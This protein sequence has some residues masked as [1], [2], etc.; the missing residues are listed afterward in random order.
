METILRIF[1]I[2][3]V[4]N[5]IL[6]V[7]GMLVIFRVAA[8]VAVPGVDATALSSIF[9]G[10]QLFGLL[11]IFSGGTLESFSVVAMGVAPYI[12]SSIIFQLLG[13]IVPQIEE[14]QKEEQGKQK[15]TQW[16]RLATVPLGLI[17][18]YG[19]ILLLS[20][21]GSIFQSSSLSTMIF[22]MVTMTAG[23]IF[24][25]W[26]GELI[27]EKN[28][29]NGISMLILAGIIAGLPTFLSQSLSIYD[30]S[31]LITMLLFVAVVI[32][33]I[34]GVVVMNEA[35]R[36]VPVQYTRH[37]RGSRL[38]G[39]VTSH[40]PLRLNMSGVIPII[41]AISIILFPT[42]LAQF[43]LSART[44][45]LRNAATWTLQLFQ[46]QVFYGITY[47]TMVFLFAYFYTSVIF[48]PDQVAENIQKQG[49]FIPGIRPGRNTADYLGWVTNR[50]LLAGASF[51][52]MIAVLPL[53][54][55]AFTGNANLVIGGTSI[56]IIVSVVIDSVKQIQAQ[57]T[58]REYDA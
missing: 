7:L 20:Q 50:L 3:D 33:T 14:M 4:R 55:Q 43:F 49:G 17:Q 8:H 29:G 23:T 30:K 57:V 12:T 52:A 26:L 19:L 22:A 24:L 53:L 40:I 32:L 45:F 5:S 15:I 28:I 58:M 54:V 6:F 11:N 16:T 9:N 18:A 38:S 42:V 21:Q 48:H 41:F 39:A 56:L 34:V 46:D 1:K 10:N 31:Q 25:V 47:F 37:V 35:Q 13:M 51:L 44:E 27:S 2:K 36:N